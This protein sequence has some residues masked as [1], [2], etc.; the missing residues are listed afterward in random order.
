MYGCMMLYVCMCVSDCIWVYVYVRV[1]SCMYVRTDE[2]MKH[3]SY[4][5]A[6]APKY[7]YYNLYGGWSKCLFLT[8]D[9]K[10]AI[11]YRCRPFP[12]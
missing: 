12:M 11:P 2:R 4:V 3:V 1:C 8:I 5:C 9:I 10:T 7:L 6:F